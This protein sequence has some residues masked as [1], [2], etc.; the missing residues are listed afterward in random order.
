MVETLLDVGLA[1]LP[2]VLPP[3]GR[4]EI[5][6]AVFGLMA[7][8]IPE[9]ISLTRRSERR[10]PYPRLAKLIPLESEDAAPTA[11]PMVVAGKQISAGGFGFFHQQPIIE[12]YAQIL[13]E[14]PSGG[15][16]AV[17]MELRWCRFNRLGWYE[18]GGRFLANRPERAR[19]EA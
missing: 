11:K 4:A 5:R 17:T 9:G 10:F 1:P 2:L 3:D 8:H 12:R 6:E 15:Q 18:S 7:A 19:R 14:K 16:F 13:F